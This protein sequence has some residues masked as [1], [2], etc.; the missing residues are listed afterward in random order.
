ME[1][2]PWTPHKSALQL[3]L[4]AFLKEL[5]A[6]GPAKTEQERAVMPLWHDNGPGIS[7]I[8]PVVPPS[9]QF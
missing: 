2:R 6:S 3:V 1:S 5:V 4:S 9:D 8:T 7:A